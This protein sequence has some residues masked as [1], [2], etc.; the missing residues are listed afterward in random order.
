M[1]PL[2]PGDWR[3]ER[4]GTGSVALFG[5]AGAGLVTLRCDMARRQITLSLSGAAVGQSVPVTIRTTSGTLAWTGTAGTTQSQVVAISRP[6]SDPGFDWI[7]Y[8]R[9]RVSVEAQGMTRLI[10][11]VWAEISRVIEDCRG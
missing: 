10:L 8:S 11:P 1:A 6:A 7:S 3:Y 4:Q 9:G 5:G 2:T